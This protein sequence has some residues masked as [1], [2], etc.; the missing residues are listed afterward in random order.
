MTLGAP[1]LELLQERTARYA[2]VCISGPTARP[3]SVRLV[4]CLVFTCVRHPVTHG[5]Y[6]RAHPGS[7]S[8]PATPR[9]R[10]PPDDDAPRPAPEGGSSA[11]K[12][13]IGMPRSEQ[14]HCDANHTAAFCCKPPT[15]RRDQ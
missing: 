7:P 3:A 9:G 13:V 5:P 11:D 15:V 12:P 4:S 10:G 8:T 6:S 14:R 2:P 1:V